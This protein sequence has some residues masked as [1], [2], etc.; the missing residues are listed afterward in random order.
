MIAVADVLDHW[1]P[2]GGD[3]SFP[4]HEE[5]L[6]HR[7]WL[8]GKAL[9]APAELQDEDRRSLVEKLPPRLPRQYPLT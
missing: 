3:P 7:Q 6:L 9:T 2:C 5:S 4:M 8:L 1:C